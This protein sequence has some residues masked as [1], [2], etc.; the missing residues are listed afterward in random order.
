MN[1]TIR[2]EISIGCYG[3]IFILHFFDWHYW[4]CHFSLRDGVLVG[5]S[6]L[7]VSWGL[8]LWRVP[9][10]LKGLTPVQIRWRIREALEELSLK[11][12]NP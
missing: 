2:R 3:A 7:G 5:A 6:C 12:P 4:A 8:Q 11:G 9:R 1:I 10:C